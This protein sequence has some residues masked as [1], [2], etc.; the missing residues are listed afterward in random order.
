[1]PN[2]SEISTATASTSHVVQNM[3]T[4]NDIR[5]SVFDFAIDYIPLDKRYKNE[6]KGGKTYRVADIEFDICPGIGT[7]SSNS[8]KSNTI[9]NEF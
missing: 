6:M 2:F 7:K 5:T 1:M 4:I 3:C 9:N 8:R